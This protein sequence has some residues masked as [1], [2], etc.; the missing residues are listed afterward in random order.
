MSSDATGE[1]VAGRA[2]GM[3]EVKVEYKDDKRMTNVDFTGAAAVMQI[4][5]GTAMLAFTETCL[6]VG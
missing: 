1:L 3:G 2:L 5:N 4:S 6:D